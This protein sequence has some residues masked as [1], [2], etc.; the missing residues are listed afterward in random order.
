MFEGTGRYERSKY[1]MNPSAYNTKPTLYIDS[2]KDNAECQ[3][4]CLI[5]TAYIFSPIL[6][7]ISQIYKLCCKKKR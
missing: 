6:W 5:C 3:K 7:P 2:T 4:S 1:R